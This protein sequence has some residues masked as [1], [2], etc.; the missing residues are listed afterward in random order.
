LLGSCV[1]EREECPTFASRTSKKRKFSFSEP[2]LE[3]SDCS[4]DAVLICVSVQYLQQPEKVFAEIYRVL[5]PGGVCI[6][7]FS[8]R[9]FYEKVRQFYTSNAYSHP[10]FHT[11]VSGSF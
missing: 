5:K 6:V 3:A 11:V 4:F 10:L 2:K 8:N 9:M 7:S 1:S